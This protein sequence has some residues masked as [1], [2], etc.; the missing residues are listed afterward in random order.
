MRE[1]LNNGEENNREKRDSVELNNEQQYYVTT[2]V[3]EGSRRVLVSQIGSRGTISSYRPRRNLFGQSMSVAFDR[4]AHIEL[5]PGRRTMSVV[6]QTSLDNMDGKDKKVWCE[7]YRF[8]FWKI[9][10]FFTSVILHSMKKSIISLILSCAIT[11]FMVDILDETNYWYTKLKVAKQPITILG[12]FVTFALVFRT[13]VC[14]DRWWESRIYWGNL[15]AAVTHVARQGSVWIDDKELQ[16]RFVAYCIVFSYACKSEL[17]SNK[18]DDEQEEGKNFVELTLLSQEELGDILRNGNSCGQTCVDMLWSIMNNVFTS[19]DGLDPGIRRMRSTI[20][21]RMERSI[22]ELSTILWSLKRLKTTGMP[23]TYDYFVNFTILVFVL[24]SSFV[25]APN[26]GWYTPITTVIII[27]V[28][29]A[30]VF[31]GDRMADC[32]GVHLV[33]LPMQ[34]YCISIEKQIISCYSNTSVL[35]GRKKR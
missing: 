22:G 30:V 6:T 18:F 8:A 34:K 9:K 21:R 14:Y 7:T 10:D 32:F 1:E 27:F 33:G 24:A 31:I 4:A 28:L 17:R 5:Q 12:T 16:D 2:N 25:W 19:H 15:S 11:A 26:L 13:N 23:I 3:C 20:I 29:N 35:E